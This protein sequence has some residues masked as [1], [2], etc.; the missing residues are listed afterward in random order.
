MHVAGCFEMLVFICGSA[1]SHP[2]GLLRWEVC[3]V[4]DKHYR[5]SGHAATVWWME[6]S[7]ILPDQTA[8]H[9]IKLYK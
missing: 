2:K 9:P 3:T 5:Y 7:K 4:V 1:V 8:S 6:F